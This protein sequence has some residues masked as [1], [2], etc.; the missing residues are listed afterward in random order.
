LAIS[1]QIAEALEAAHEQYRASRSQAGQR[2]AEAAYMSPEQ[3]K[4]RHVDKRT[5][6][7]SFGVSG[8]CGGAAYGAGG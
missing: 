8:S 4:G 7:W 2:Q 5:D 1:R 3:A 6:I